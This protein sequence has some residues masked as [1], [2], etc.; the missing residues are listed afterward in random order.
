VLL[1]SVGFF[2][3]RFWEQ[4]SM[5]FTLMFR[6][7]S[8]RRVLARSLQTRYLGITSKLLARLGFSFHR[9]RLELLSLMVELLKASINGSVHFF[10]HLIFYRLLSVSL[11]ACRPFVPAMRASRTISDLALVAL[12]FS[13]QRTS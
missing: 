1:Q 5:D 3:L 4:T 7:T 10:L 2:P 9:S 13:L 12:M 8:G 6:R 11:R